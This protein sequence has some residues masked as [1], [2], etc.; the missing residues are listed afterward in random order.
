MISTRADVNANDDFLTGTQVLF[1]SLT[2]DGKTDHTLFGAP[3]L[4]QWGHSR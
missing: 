4:A 1:S 3:G 2:G